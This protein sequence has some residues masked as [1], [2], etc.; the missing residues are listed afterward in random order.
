MDRDDDFELLRVCFERSR[1]ALPPRFDHQFDHQN[2]GAPTEYDP[3]TREW[4]RNLIKTE[5]FYKW[6]FV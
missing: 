4:K 5:I 2:A 1:D 6:A 3:P